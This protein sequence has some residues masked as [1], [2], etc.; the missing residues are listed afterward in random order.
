MMQSSWQCIICGTINSVRLTRTKYHGKC[1]G[2]HIQSFV[3]NE[4]KI[5]ERLSWDKPNP[6]QQK[7]WQCP[8]CHTMNNIGLS[9]T[10]YNGH[11]Y[12]CLVYRLNKSDAIYQSHWY[13]PVWKYIANAI[14]YERSRRA[15]LQQPLSTRC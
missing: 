5:I 14:E 8:H 11:C 13:N 12:G 3:A 15:R 6:N 2:C 4:T 9:I 1:C 7:C 10:K